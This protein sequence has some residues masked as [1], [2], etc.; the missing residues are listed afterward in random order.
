MR[1][2][3]LPF[4]PDLSQVQSMNPGP[5]NED[6]RSSPRRAP[7]YSPDEIRDLRIARVHFRD[8]YLFC[9]LSDGNM[10]CVP[11]TIAPKLMAAQ[12]KARYQWQLEQGGRSLAWYAGNVGIAFERLTLSTI[13]AHPEAQIS[14]G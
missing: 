12:H 6:R 5:P 7:A 8:K 11:L 10:V 14:Q 1:S 4:H 13:L 9:L 2:H 3:L